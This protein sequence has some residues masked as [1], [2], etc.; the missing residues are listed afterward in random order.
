MWLSA[1]NGFIRCQSRLQRTVS[2][3]SKREPWNRVQHALILFEFQLIYFSEHEVLIFQIYHHGLAFA[4][5]SLHQKCALSLANGRATKG[6]K[7]N[8]GLSAF[9]AAT[10][11]ML[12]MAHNTLSVCA[13]HQRASIDN[14]LHAFMFSP[15]KLCLWRSVWARVM[16]PTSVTHTCRHCRGTSCAVWDR[17]RK[18]LQLRQV[19]HQTRH[20][21]HNI[22]PLNRVV[23]E[24]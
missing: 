5:M 6:Q 23:F 1:S 3:K 24:L 22:T 19:T 20:W 12:V 11:W 9:V 10:M 14:L 4:S 8:F 21:C 13:M 18:Q 7:V 16:G 2:P 17:R 15:S